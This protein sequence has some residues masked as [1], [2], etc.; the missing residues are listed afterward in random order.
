MA[1]ETRTDPAFA[2]VDVRRLH[3]YRNKKGPERVT[4]F[5]LECYKTLALYL[6]GTSDTRRI[7]KGA[8]YRALDRFS[9]VRNFQPRAGLLEYRCLSLDYGDPI[10]A[11]KDYWECIPRQEYTVFSPQRLESMKD[12]I[13][14]HISGPEFEKPAQ[15]HH[16]VKIESTPLT[17]LPETAIFSISEFLDNDSLINLFCASSEIYSGLTDNDSFWRRRIITHLPYFFELHEYLKEQSQ[18]LKNRDFRRIFLWADAASKPRPGVTRVMFPVAN[19][20]RIWNVCEQIG[21]VYN[22]EP[23]Q[24][25]VTGSYLGCRCRESER[26][27]LGDT[28]E[29]VL[30]FRS[31]YF[32][33][34]WTELLRPWTLDLFWNLE[35]DLSGM[36]V[37]F[38]QGQR[39]F[40]HKP[41]ESDSC[42]TTGSFAGG[43]WIKGFVFHIYAS[44]ALRSR[45][46]CS[47]NYSS[48]KGVT[49]YLTDGS[50][51][52]YGQEA[53][54][55]TR[56]AFSAAQD[57]PIV[58]IKGT[59]TAHKTYGISP[60]IEKLRILQAA[61][62]GGQFYREPLKLR[63]QEVSCWSPANCMFRNLMSPTDDLKLNLC[64]GRVRNFERWHCLVPL[65]T[66]VLAN[67]TSELSQIRSISAY[68]IRDP[69]CFNILNNHCCDVGSLRVT[70]DAGTRYL[71]DVDDD[72]SIWPEQRW[73]MF[74]IDGPG[75]ETIEE[76]IVHHAL[77][78][79]SSPKAVE[80]CTNR[81]RS[82]IWGVDMER[83]EDGEET[84]EPCP[85]IQSHRLPTHLSPD[86]GFAIVGSSEAKHL[87]VIHIQGD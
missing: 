16:E 60:L 17:A 52:T 36:A 82:V 56:M 9:V 2:G 80:I 25:A 85:P 54:H 63:D 42:Q 79:D 28:G 34:D 19:R 3:A 55:L 5:H 37:T 68:L 18:S 49:L 78:R 70:T 22:Q 44:S 71:R 11:Q 48:C 46:T 15:H 39:I 87:I 30:Y 81:G 69:I 7:R 8:V 66:L 53:E 47:W 67:D 14:K 57:M 6:T 84:N 31:A 12:D 33:R 65:N 86:D 64:K 62:N 41:Q 77:F 83:G 24:R 74:S 23:Q 10:E 61:T 35:G 72:G 45:Q 21:K 40:G 32:L 59:L 58:G 1:T 4:P 38:E 50:E 20:R 43:I 27:V 13:A 29:P 76:V 26:Q 73:D 75:G 51:H